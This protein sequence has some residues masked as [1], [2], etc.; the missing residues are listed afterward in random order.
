MGLLVVSKPLECQDITCPWLAKSAY[1]RFT[2]TAHRMGEAYLQVILDF[3]VGTVA[4]DPC[5][6]S[7]H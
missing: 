3:R 2:S 6:F 4:L 7:P 5:V 1:G